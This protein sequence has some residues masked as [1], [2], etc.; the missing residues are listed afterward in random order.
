MI[1]ATMKGDFMS[2]CIFGDS[3]AKGI[4]YDEARKRYILIKNCFAGLFAEKTDFSVVNFARFGCT[5]T[6]GL[7]LLSRQKETLPSFSHVILGFGGND[8]DMKWDEVSKAPEDVHQP[9]VPLMQFE[10]IYLK[11]IDIVKAAG[12]I[13]VMLSLPP[14]DSERFFK[15]V[16]KELDRENIK[17]FLG[18]IDFIY[19]WHE[20]YDAVVKKL[21]ERRSI[22]LVDIRSVFLQEDRYSDLLCVDGMHPNEKGHALISKL[23]CDI[24]K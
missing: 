1:S 19:K 10:E 3:V 12:S 16:S 18:D 14:L 8:C 11:M 22:L 21:A 5:A 6:K 9:N 24:I 7:E 2:I 23:L 17:K 15:W 13:P 4:V 20:S